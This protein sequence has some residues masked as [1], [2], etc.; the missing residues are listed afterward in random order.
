MFGEVAVE[1]G[2]DASDLVLGVND[3]LFGG[4]SVADHASRQEGGER[5]AGGRAGE[6]TSVAGH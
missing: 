3:R 6:L 4:G 1:L 5:S 2:L